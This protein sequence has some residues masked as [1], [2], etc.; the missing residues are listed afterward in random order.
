M[1]SFA[2]EIRDI[3]WS[4]TNGSV[5]LYRVWAKNKKEAEKLILEY[6]YY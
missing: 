1:K 3:T 4:S 6:V 5:L 2:I